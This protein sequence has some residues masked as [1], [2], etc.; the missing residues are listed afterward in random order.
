MYINVNKYTYT[1][2]CS[3]IC[4]NIEHQKQTDHKQQTVHQQH[5][6]IAS[7]IRCAN[8]NNTD[9]HHLNHHDHHSHPH[10]CFEAKPFT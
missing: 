3:R 4:V 10:E 9:S 2:L 5:T 8:T 6:D 7:T 1:Y